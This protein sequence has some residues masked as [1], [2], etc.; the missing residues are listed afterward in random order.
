MLYAIIS[1]DIANSLEKRLSVRPAHLKRLQELQDAGRL[2]LA[3]PHPAIDSD[4]PGEAG[5]TGS[6]VV[7]EFDSLTDAQQWADVDPYVGAGVYAKVTVKP[8]K[9]VF[10]Q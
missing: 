5:F 7:A 1:E 8:F 10:P 3:G 9:K 2:V 6:L 4:N